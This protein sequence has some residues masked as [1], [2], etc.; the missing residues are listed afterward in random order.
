[1]VVTQ[2]F[3][4]C[5]TPGELTALVNTIAPAIHTGG[6]WLFADFVLP[7]HGARRALARTLVTALYAFFRWTTGITARA[8][9]PSEEAIR[10]AGFAAIDDR[11]LAG[12]L[13]RSVVFTKTSPTPAVARSLRMDD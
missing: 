2:F 10:A 6:L 9:P 8:L 12:G 3:L 5:F 11:T 1:M 7:P 13:V 4:D